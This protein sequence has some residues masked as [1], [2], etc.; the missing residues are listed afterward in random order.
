[1]KVLFICTGNTCRSPMAEGILKKLLR[2][3]ARTDV[4]CESAG[5]ATLDGLSASDNSITVCKEIGVDISTHFSKSVQHINLHDYTWI[6]PLT[7]RHADVLKNLGASEKS[8]Y[9]L[10]DISDPFGL[11]LDTYRECRNDIRRA[12]TRFYQ[13]ELK[14]DTNNDCK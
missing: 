6:V 7:N 9:V 1:M 2:E 14:S 12:V 5:I 4:F 3:D 8:I 11:D 13:E 10:Q